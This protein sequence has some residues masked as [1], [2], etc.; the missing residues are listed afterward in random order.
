MEHKRNEAA[1]IPTINN[2]KDAKNTFPKDS[3]ILG[4]WVNFQSLEEEIF[5]VKGLFDP[6]GLM[7]FPQKFY[8]WHYGPYA[9][10]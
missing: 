2:K 9:L 10:L 1:A 6:V 8:A 4:R 7:S 3:F 5:H